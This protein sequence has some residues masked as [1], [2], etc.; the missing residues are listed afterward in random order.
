MKTWTLRESQSAQ[1]PLG[2]QAS[3]VPVNTSNRSIFKEEGMEGNWKN[4]LTQVV[5]RYLFTWISSI[6]YV[7]KKFSETKH[8]DE[9]IF[10]FLQGQHISQVYLCCIKVFL[11]KLMRNPHKS[12]ISLNF[13]AQIFKFESSLQKN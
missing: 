9:N 4:L 7:S 8:F 5:S 13:Y 6:S 3:Q 10:E 1:T 11:V 2:V 12:P